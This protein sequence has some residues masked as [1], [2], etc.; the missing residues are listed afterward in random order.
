MA[1]ERR[2]A[3]QTREH[4]LGVAADLF[5]WHGIRATGIDTV[6]RAAGVAPTTLYRLFADKDDLVAA[7]LE[8][9]AK[10]YR[11]WFTAA[12][13]RGGDDPRARITAVFDALAIQTRPEVCRGCPFQLALAEIPD[14]AQ[15]AHRHATQVKRWVRTRFRRMAKDLGAA[16]P[17]VLGDQLALIMEGVY[18]T[19]AAF[20]GTGPT[21][22]TGRLVD[23]LLSSTAPRR[24]AAPRQS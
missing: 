14:S 22:T 13:A 2:S 17:T 11:E 20:G 6:A 7:Y 24:R 1:R 4:V 21:A 15:A 9:Q 10:G 8:R 18:A 12:Q 3:E 23:L 16:D 5:Y 19:V